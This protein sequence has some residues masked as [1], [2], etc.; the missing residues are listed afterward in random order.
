MTAQPLSA[1]A[2]DEAKPWAWRGQTIAE[3]DEGENQGP[4]WSIVNDGVMGGLSKGKVEISKEGIMTFSGTLSLENNGG[5]SL[6]ETG[7]IDRNLSND[8]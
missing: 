3:F 8:L 5:F 4:D 6:A 1:E 2:R 7:K